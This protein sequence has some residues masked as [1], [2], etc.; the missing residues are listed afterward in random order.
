MFELLKDSNSAQIAVRL[1]SNAGI[2]STNMSQQRIVSLIKNL[3]SKT[4]GSPSANLVDVN[5]IQ[6][7]EISENGNQLEVAE[8]GTPSTEI[9]IDGTQTSQDVLNITP[10]GKEVN[11]TELQGIEIQGVD[12][13]QTFVTITD[14]ADALS[15]ANGDTNQVCLTYL[16]T[17]TYSQTNIHQSK[18]YYWR[19]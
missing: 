5:N 19:S 17:N 7:L 18:F 9:A 12:G 3:H 8:N 13:Q 4:T 11:L 14:L 16:V 15:S 6:L 2:D 1:K 10:L